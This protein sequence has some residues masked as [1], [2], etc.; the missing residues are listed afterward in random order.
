MK[1]FTTNLKW[2]VWKSLKSTASLAKLQKR[3][4]TS[5]KDAIKIVHRDIANWGD[6]VNVPLVESISQRKVLNCDIDARHYFGL[7]KNYDEDSIYMVVG[8]IVGSADCQT[9]IWGAGLQ[10]ANDIPRQKPKKVCAVRGPLTAAALNENGIDAP[11]IFG[12]PV[13]L[14]PKYYDAKPEPK[15]YKVGIVAHRK[16]FHD[17]L[18][19]KFTND[20]DI[21][22]INMRDCTNRIVDKIASCDGIISTSLHGVIVAD[23]YGVPSAWG[24]VSERIPGGF[25]KYKDY[26]LSIGDP[27]NE[28]DI[29]FG[30]STTKSD[31]ISA[32]RR[33]TLNI[34][35]DSLY[36]ACPFKSE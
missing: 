25:F 6:A 30:E 4:L 34:D 19:A 15:R 5:P 20:P 24:R 11:S 28:P 16:D 23:A 13:L 17:P 27:Q 21:L 26:Y 8:S 14:L 33:R 32:P 12:D 36:Q 22:I 3:K 10:S 31:L 35:L 7:P 29:Y 2:T 18:V 9:I 1:N